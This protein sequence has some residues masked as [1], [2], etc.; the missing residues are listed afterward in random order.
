ML[1]IEN[2]VKNQNTVCFFEAKMSVLEKLCELSNQ[3]YRV[4]LIMKDIDE[5]LLMEI[6]TNILSLLDHAYL[7]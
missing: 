5:R 1:I 7:A 3:R 4:E 6:A 2:F